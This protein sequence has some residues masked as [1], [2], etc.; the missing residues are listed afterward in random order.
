M[1]AYRTLSWAELLARL[2]AGPPRD[3][4]AWH[5]AHV[6]LQG[7]ARAALREGA[8]ADPDGVLEVTNRVLVKLHRSPVLLARLASPDGRGD[9][10]AYLATVVYTTAVDY[11]REE[12]RRVRRNRPL[13]NP[14]EVPAKS[15]S[16]AREVEEQDSAAELRRILQGLLGPADWDLLRQRFW[17][18]RS[19]QEIAAA[20]KVPYHTA[21]MRLHR[22]QRKLLELLP[23]HYGPP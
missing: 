9:P 16:P 2:R 4:A 10:Q 6:R 22:L 3:E 17:E 7:Y 21:A 23:R 15:Q 20:L 12:A 8:A 11:R 14:E 19:L 5:E 1:N 18:E 13:D